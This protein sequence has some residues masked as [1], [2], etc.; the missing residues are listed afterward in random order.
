MA[1]LS[2]CLKPRSQVDGRML[3][4]VKVVTL[5]MYMRLLHAWQALY[6]M[7]LPTATLGRLKGDLYLAGQ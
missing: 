7:Q 3:E 5:E 2:F 4:L 6:A 1:D